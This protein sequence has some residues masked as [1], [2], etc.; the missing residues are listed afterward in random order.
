VWGFLRR[1]IPTAC[2]TGWIRTDPREGTRISLSVARVL[3]GDPGLLPAATLLQLGTT[4]AAAALRLKEVGS[5]APG[6]A[7][8][9]AS[10]AGSAPS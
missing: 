7:V 5:L 4:G 1:G 9:P 3:T 2:A 8:S 6:Q 10:A